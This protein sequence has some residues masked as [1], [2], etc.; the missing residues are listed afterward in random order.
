MGVS[1]DC[2]EF[3]HTSLQKALA[4]LGI[5]YTMADKEA[6]SVP[7]I[8]INDVSFLKRKWVKNEKYGI[9][10]CPLEWESI[11]KMLTVWTASKSIDYHEQAIAVFTSAIMES[12]FHGEETY[13]KMHGW[14]MEFLNKNSD[15]KPW[16]NGFPTFLQCI[17]NFTIKSDE[18]YVQQSG[19]ILDYAYLV[20]PQYP[21]FQ[22]IDDTLSI[23]SNEIEAFENNPRIND[24]FRIRSIIKNNN[25]VLK[26]LEQFNRPEDYNFIRLFRLRHNLYA[27][28]LRRSARQSAI[29]F[30]LR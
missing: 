6:K 13:N 17:K 10:L 23:I 16:F 4:N 28:R 22:L 1:K 12:A 27:A 3:T 9:V 24:Y 26:S 29:A 8:H 19:N 11:E 30:F 18:N 20:H 14:I 2:S 21:S 7:Y 15:Y 25:R 5:E